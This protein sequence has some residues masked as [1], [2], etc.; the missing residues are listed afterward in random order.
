MGTKSAAG[1]RETEQAPSAA[2]QARIAAGAKGSGTAVKSGNSMHTI[3]RAL[4]PMQVLISIVAFVIW[5]VLVVRMVSSTK[6]EGLFVGYQRF[7]S[8]HLPR[9]MSAWLDIKK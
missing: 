1:A 3:K 5:V 2:L 6:V 7:A 8:I 4:Q 9:L